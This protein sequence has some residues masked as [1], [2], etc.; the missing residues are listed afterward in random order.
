MDWLVGILLVIVGAVIGFFGARFYFS[1]YSDTAQ[2]QAQVDTSREQLAAYRKDVVE[3][4]QTARQLSEQLSE[5]QQKLNTFL[6]DSQ[7]MLKQEKEWQQPLPFFAED[8]IRQLRA[9]NTFDNDSR[10]AQVK[11][12]TQDAP[13][14]YSDGSSGLLSEQERNQSQN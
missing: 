6:A 2:L 14:D 12:K 3:H 13:L 4:F 9:A 11:N 1:K 10:H 7:T 8:T 5:T